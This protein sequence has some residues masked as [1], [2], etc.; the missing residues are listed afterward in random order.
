M[1]PPRNIWDI[2][3][4]SYLRLNADTASWHPNLP[5][6]SI[7]PHFIVFSV[8]SCNPEHREA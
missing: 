1:N 3:Q 2:L 7:Y 4:G 5:L 8:A 6:D